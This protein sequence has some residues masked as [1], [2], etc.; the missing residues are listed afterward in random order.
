MPNVKSFILQPNEFIN[1]GKV[2]NKYM[3][4]ER[5]LNL[6][7]SQKL[8]FANPIE[9]PD[10]F[11]RRFIDATYFGKS[12]F[13]WKNRVFCSCFTNNA[14]SEASWNAYSK[15]DICIKFV[16]DRRELLNVL[17]NYLNTN[18]Y[19]QVYFD[20]VE[21]MQ[22]RDITNP[23]SKIPFK[24]PLTQG[25]GIRSMEF[26]E[27]LLLL[28]RKAFEYEEEYR[29]IIVKRK[30]TKAKG[31]LVDIPDVHAL[32]KKIMV[33]PSVGDDTFTVLKNVFVDTYGYKMTQIERSD[34]Y[35]VLPSVINIKTNDE[36]SCRRDEA[37]ALA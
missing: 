27:R 36:S 16:I 20:K 11:E 21:Y 17:E 5:A 4:F 25:A 33:A 18:G 30:A 37:V 29:A 31:I 12:K 1:S 34:L 35:K 13:A 3:P 15:G 24:P 14:T 9:W 23:L 19:I 28:K 22:S 2:V 32:I 26:K 7:N 6:L 8:W 10:P